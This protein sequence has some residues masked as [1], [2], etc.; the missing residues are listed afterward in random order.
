MEKK[1][2]T[3]SKCIRVANKEL[4]IRLRREE[5]TL[6]KVI[7]LYQVVEQRTTANY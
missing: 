4:Q 3:K 5:L 1:C 7:K 6:E 2:N